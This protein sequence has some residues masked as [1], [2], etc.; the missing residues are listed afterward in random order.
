MISIT[1]LASVPIVSRTAF[2]VCAARLST[3]RRP[4]P[5]LD[6]CRGFELLASYS[7]GWPKGS[8]RRTRTWSTLRA[9]A[10]RTDERVISGRSPDWRAAMLQA[11]EVVG[12]VV[13]ASAEPTSKEWWVAVLADPPGASDAPIWHLRGE[14]LYRLQSWS[15][16]GRGDCPSCR[17]CRRS[18][19]TCSM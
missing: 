4:L 11:R 12:S 9:F 14:T 10:T 3:V 19:R 16:G 5:S 17:F 7:D 8:W 2:T 6:R 1:N 18:L 13:V 15:F